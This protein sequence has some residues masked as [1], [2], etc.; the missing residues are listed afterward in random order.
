[1]QR[2]RPTICIWKEKEN[3]KGD[4]YIPSCLG[5][6]CNGINV[7]KV[8][9][10]KNITIIDMFRTCPYCGDRVQIKPCKK[11]N[12]IHYAEIKENN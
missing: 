1:M 4:V 2:I 7:W 12:N 3:G 9:K 8:A 6:S 11:E 10:K 5:K